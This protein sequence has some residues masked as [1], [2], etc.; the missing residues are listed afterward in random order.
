MAVAAGFTGRASYD[1]NGKTAQFWRIAA[2]YL[3]FAQ[4]FFKTSLHMKTLVTILCLFLAAAVHAETVKL[5][6]TYNDVP[7]SDC[8]IT[9]KIGDVE[10]GTGRTNSSGDVSINAKKLISKSIDVYGSKKTAN[11]TKTWNAK[12]FA[13]L[14]N[15]NYCHLKMDVVVKQMADMSGM[16]EAT[17]ASMWGLAASG[18]NDATASSGNAGGN[19]SAASSDDDDDN[20]GGAGSSGGGKKKGTTLLEKANKVANAGSNV[21]FSSE[22]HTSS[23]STGPDGHKSSSS[24]SKTEG[25]FGG[26]KA[27]MKTTKE[28]SNTTFDDNGLNGSSSKSTKSTSFPTGTGAGKSSGS[29]SANNNNTGSGNSKS[30]DNGSDSKSSGKSSTPKESSEVKKTR[31]Q[32]AD[33][34]VTVEALNKKIVDQQS[35]L[36]VLKAEKYPDT[37]TIGY[38]SN[39]LEN[40]KLQREREQL[41]IEK[42][43][44]KISGEKL[45]AERDAAIMS[46]LTEIEFR[47]KQLTELEKASKKDRDDEKD[48]REKREE[49]IKKEDEFAKDLAKVNTLNRME[50]NMNLTEFKT[51]YQREKANFAVASKMMSPEK[52]AENEKDIENLKTLIDKY[53]ARLAELKAQDEAEKKAKE[54]GGK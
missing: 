48:R 26:G 27:S 31:S 40:V 36:M 25:S 7:V 11:S 50:L 6:I 46:R 37:I 49:K 22:T 54:A 17:L 5:K 47:L 32:K 16:S 4:P 13:V 33:R 8:D 51:R 35:E 15:S 39:D 18:K 53:E 21:S 42:L 14:D 2:D 3:K 9:I 38:K 19:K 43:D 34:E 52:K 44:A 45:S 20:N 23:S 24:S 1:L 41:E 10:L 30:S 12:G 28:S 29:G